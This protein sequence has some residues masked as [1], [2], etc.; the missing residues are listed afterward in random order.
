MGQIDAIH[1][2]A[3][4][5]IFIK[6]DHSLIRIISSKAFNEIQL[7]SNCPTA[8]SGRL[9]NSLNNHFSATNDIGF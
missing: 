8:P 9:S 3:V 4:T 2:G 5:D 7:S 6:E 1:G